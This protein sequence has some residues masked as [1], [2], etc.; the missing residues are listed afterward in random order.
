[1]NKISKR[2]LP[3]IGIGLIIILLIILFI[4]SQA[5]L[6]AAVEPDYVGGIDS[7]SAAAVYLSGFGWETA[8][9]AVKTVVIPS[10]FSPSYEEY[11]NLQKSQ[12]FDLSRHRSEEV[13]VYTFR[14]LN[15]PSDADVFA[16]VMVIGGNVIGGDVVSYAINGFLTGLDGSV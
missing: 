2:N 15:H 3:L 10:E 14:I 1:M 6:N 13:T 11:N 12:G 8:P 9:S 4:A 16:N 5:G 7:A